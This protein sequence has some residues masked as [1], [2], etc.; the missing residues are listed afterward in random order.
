MVI[1]LSTSR[2]PVLRRIRAWRPVVDLLDLADPDRIEIFVNNN[3][4]ANVNGLEYRICSSI[5]LIV[6]ASH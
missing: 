4:F 1:A 5:P 3:P 2:Q 6:F